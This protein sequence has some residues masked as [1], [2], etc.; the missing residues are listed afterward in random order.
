MVVELHGYQLDT[1]ENKLILV[2][3]D[4]G[5]GGILRALPPPPQ[6][7]CTLYLKYRL[8]FIIEHIT[9]IY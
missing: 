7:L 6:Q 3:N 9:L 4:F 2:R 1:T 8:I 5:G